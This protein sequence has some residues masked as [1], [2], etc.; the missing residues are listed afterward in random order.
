MDENV[1]SVFKIIAAIIVLFLCAVLIMAVLALIF[2]LSIMPVVAFS[3]LRQ[4]MKARK[5]RYDREMQSIVVAEFVPPPDLSPAELGYLLDRKIGRRERWAT[6]LDLEARGV[7]WV[8]GINKFEVIDREKYQRCNELEKFCMKAFGGK[9]ATGSASD[10]GAKDEQ[11]HK[12]DT[13]LGYELQQSLKQKG[14]VYDT[15]IK[16]NQ[17]IVAR[18]ITLNVLGIIAAIFCWLV[19]ATMIIGQK[20]VS[21]EALASALMAVFAAPVATA[22]IVAATSL[23]IFALSY[24]FIGNYIIFTKK[25]DDIWDEI[26]GFRRYVYQASRTRLEQATAEGRLSKD[27]T[28]LLPYAIV[29]NVPIDA[30]K[31]I[32]TR[33][34]ARAK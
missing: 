19:V 23:V 1:L 7:I 6:M 33:S 30:E 32:K 14:Y 22:G 29:M 3:L 26:E 9:Q 2:I 28:K 18:K 21:F 5:Y 8:Q 24:K 34:T 16:A 15:S 10:R 13:K 25:A 4:Y 17:D 12:I 27:D 31:Y 11:A 20:G